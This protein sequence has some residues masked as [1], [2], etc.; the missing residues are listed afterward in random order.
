M[1]KK[2]DYKCTGCGRWVRVAKSKPRAAISRRGNL[3]A[4][5]SYSQPPM[6]GDLVYLYCSLTTCSHGPDKGDHVFV[7]DFDQG[8][9]PD[10]VLLDG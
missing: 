9:V 7:S 3:S 8:K 6:K 2:T 1:S 10:W 5:R 4:K